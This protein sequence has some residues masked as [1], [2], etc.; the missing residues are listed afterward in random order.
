MS[1]DTEPVVGQWYRQLDKGYEFKVVAVDEDEGIVHIQ[2]L[3]DEVEELDIDSW[4]E[5]DVET[6]APYDKISRSGDTLTPDEVAGVPSESRSDSH[7][8]DVDEEE[9]DN[10]TL[11]GWEDR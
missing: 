7:D 4:Y 1:W 8:E 9:D 6:I 3:D 11:D 2:Y 10:D 5:W